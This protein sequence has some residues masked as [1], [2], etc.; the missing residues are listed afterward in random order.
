M[1]NDSRETRHHSL[2][3][4]LRG[5]GQGEGQR[6]SNAAE[7][8]GI[9]ILVLPRPERGPRRSRIKPTLIPARRAGTQGRKLEAGR[10][11]V[12]ARAPAEAGAWPGKNSEATAGRANGFM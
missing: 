10:P 8:P 7:A 12:P 4:S 3:P 9:P 11:L 6:P 5:E 2:S 1:G